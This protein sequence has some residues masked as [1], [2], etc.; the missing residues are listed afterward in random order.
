[1]LAIRLSLSYALTTTVDISKRCHQQRGSSSIQ[2]GKKIA[3]FVPDMTLLHVSRRYQTPTAKVP[4]LPSVS[5]APAPYQQ[6]ALIVSGRPRLRAEVCQNTLARQQQQLLSALRPPGQAPPQA[7]SCRSTAP[8]PQSSHQR[9]G[10]PKVLPTT[11]ILL[12]IQGDASL[13]Q[14]QPCH[15]QQHVCQPLCF[16]LYSLGRINTWHFLAFTICMYASTT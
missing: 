8:L 7:I 15:T 4:G 10:P 2:A 3:K 5:S 1:M 6:Q 9:N 12:H 11:V 13:Q 14:V 16:I